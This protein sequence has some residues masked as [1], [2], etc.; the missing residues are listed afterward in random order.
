MPDTGNKILGWFITLI[1]LACLRFVALALSFILSSFAAALFITF[2]LFLGSDFGWLEEDIL[3]AIGAIAFATS[4]WLIIASMALAP[5][6]LA[7]LVLEF[8]RFS[9]LTINLLAG[10]GVGFAVMVL[11]FHPGI[12]NTASPA[13]G[14]NRL[15]TDLPYSDGEIWAAVL[16]AGFIAGLSHW[17]LAGHRSGRWLGTPRDKTS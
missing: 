1:V 15:Q 13:N 6:L 7:F 17:I 9:S 2:V 11:S 8:G 16:S 5:S 10:G 12:E 3:S 4:S 14:D